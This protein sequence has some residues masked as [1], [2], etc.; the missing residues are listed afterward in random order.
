MARYRAEVAQFLD[1]FRGQARDIAGVTSPFHRVI[2]YSLAFD[3]L[4]RAAYCT[5]GS[6]R[7]RFV[8]LV[9][10]IAQWPEADKVSLPQ[11]QLRLRDAKRYRQKLF[12]EVSRRLR[13]WGSDGG[14]VPLSYSPS[15]ADLSSFAEPSEKSH[16]KDAQYVQLFYTYRNNLVH[17]FREPGY[18]TDWSGRSTQPFY[19]SYIDGPWELVFPVAFIAALYERTLQGLEAHLL[20][21]KINPYKQFQFGSLWRAK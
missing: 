9:Q 21:N 16:L 19:G 17:E 18:G 2:L 12:R 20:S 11:L 3:P 8:K 4:A 1:H 5:T 14:T 7:E 6:H 10:D 13:A 15:V